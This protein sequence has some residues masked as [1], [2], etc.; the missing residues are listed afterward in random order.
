MGNPM[1]DEHYASEHD[2]LRLVIF[3]LFS[4]CVILLLSYNSDWPLTH[5]YY[6]HVQERNFMHAA[7]S[8]A[9]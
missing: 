7:P 6:F 4:Y 3:V 2:I 5:T 9:R 1:N 8:K